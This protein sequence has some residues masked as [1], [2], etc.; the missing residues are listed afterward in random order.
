[1]VPVQYGHNC[2]LQKKFIRSSNKSYKCWCLVSSLVIRYIVM[3]PLPQVNLHYDMV[4][5][6]L[7]KKITKSSK[8]VM[9]FI[10]QCTVIYPLSYVILVLFCYFFSINKCQYFFLNNK[11]LAN[12]VF[13]VYLYSTLRLTLP[14][15]ESSQPAIKIKGT[16]HV[17]TKLSQ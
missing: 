7:Q 13:T 3:V 14:D 6:V 10:V 2:V 4:T 11:I 9:T 5:S 8:V 16:V 17:K 1:M 12:I 15:E